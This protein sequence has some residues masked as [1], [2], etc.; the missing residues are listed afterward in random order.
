MLVRGEWEKDRVKKREINER[1][2]CRGYLL[3]VTHERPLGYKSL[4]KI[5]VQVMNTVKVLY[6]LECYYYILLYFTVMYSLTGK[7][8]ICTLYLSTTI[9]VDDTSVNH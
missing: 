1:V 7:Y 5:L 3:S 2:S 4:K 8:N 6:P 9:A